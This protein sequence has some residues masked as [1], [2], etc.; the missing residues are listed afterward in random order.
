MSAIYYILSGD[1]VTFGPD[2]KAS[3]DILS[4]KAIIKV[5][6]TTK[7]LASSTAVVQCIHTY[8][9]STLPIYVTH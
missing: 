9:L 8:I 3:N 5:A 4:L 1:G 6:G 7:S 2:D